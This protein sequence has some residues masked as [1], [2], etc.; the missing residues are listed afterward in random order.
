MKEQSLVAICIKKLYF[1]ILS[2]C[3]RVSIIKD[4]Y[5]GWVASV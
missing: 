4:Y 1:Y 5:Y 2:K 3:D